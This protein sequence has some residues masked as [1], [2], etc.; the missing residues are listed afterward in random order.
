VEK[1]KHLGVRANKSLPDSDFSGEDDLLL[2]S[3]D[4]DS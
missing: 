2:E 1:I 4:D 3:D